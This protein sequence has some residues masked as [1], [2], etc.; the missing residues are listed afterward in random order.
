MDRIIQDILNFKEADFLEYEKYLMWGGSWK[1]P[2]LV[3]GKGIY[4]EDVNG[5]KYIDCTCQGWVLHLGHSHP[6]INNIVK[7]QL[8]Y[9]NHI[10]PFVRNPSRYLLAKKIADL[11][12]GDLKRVFFTL[13]GGPSVEAA[14]KVAIVNN[15]DAHQF[16]SLYGGYH[17]STFMT[18][19]AGVLSQMRNNGFQGAGK[20]THFF[21]CFIKTQNPYCYRCPYRLKYPD[22]KILCAD[23]LEDTI[24]KGTNG[25]VAGIILEVIQGYAGSIPL[26]KEYIKRVRDICNKYKIILI[27]DEIQTNFGRTGEWFGAT[28]CGIDPDIIVL[29]K[30]MGA[31]FVTGGLIVSNRIKGIDDAMYDIATFSNQAIPQVAMLKM[32]DIIERD[33]I[34]E[35]VKKVGGFISA[36]IKKMMKEFPEIG[37][38]RGP[39]LQIGVEFVKNPE[40]K[41]PAS[42]EV[43]KFREIGRELGIIW[44][45]A[46]SA[47]HNIV[48]VRPPLNTKMEEAQKILDLFYECTKRTFKK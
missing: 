36:E 34:L 8:E 47:Q 48:K 28:Y 1:G 11:A 10:D 13:G 35:N 33:K 45:I 41:E 40:T 44:A 38:V 2:H 14:M 46:G 26:P 32:L 7:E 17:G 27:Y 29:G 5:K 19:G 39:G 9:L 43:L 21:Q 20:L 3:K 25:P 15:P 37:D 12:P 22:C 31:G 16:I 6:E 24:T 42:D 23:L 4:V 18:A 30:S